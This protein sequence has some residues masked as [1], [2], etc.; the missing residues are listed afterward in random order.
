MTSSRRRT[1]YPITVPLGRTARRLEWGHLPPSIRS[2]VEQ[3]IG[4][5]VVEAYSQSS[6]YTPGLASV[7]VAADGSRHFVKA[8]SAKAQRAAALSYRAEAAKLRTIPPGVAVPR[9]QWVQ[10]SDDWVVLGIEYVPGRPPQRP[11]PA[12]ELDGALA[13]LVTNAR[14]LT[15]APGIGLDTL[16][17]DTADWPALWDTLGR[18]T[19]ATEARK[20]AERAS[21]VLQ[22]DTLVHGDVRDDNVLIRPDGTAVVCDWNWP[23]LGPDWFDSLYLLISARGDGVDV[24]GIIGGHP[25]LAD[26]PPEDIDTTLALLAGYFLAH[27]DKPIP[28]AAPWVREIQRWQ[29]EV[30]WQW[31]AERRGWL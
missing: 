1:A 21:T 19:G 26:V 4:S 24:D 29:G 18:V 30:S 6:G 28:R 16:I 3:Q 7:L 14:G 5:A 25:L 12:S 20:L 23:A 31:L 27:A 8:A 10:D 22:G 15:P 2:A 11:W 9:L 17:A 13:A